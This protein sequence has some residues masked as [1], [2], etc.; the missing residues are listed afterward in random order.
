MSQRLTAFPE[1]VYF[2][3]LMLSRRYPGVPSE[4]LFAR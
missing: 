2:E 4:R 1:L 3:A